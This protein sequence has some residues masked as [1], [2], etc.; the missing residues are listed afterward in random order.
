[1]ALPQR[2]EFIT[3]KFNSI[4]AYDKYGAD[5]FTNFQMLLNILVKISFTFRSMLANLI[6]KKLNN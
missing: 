5:E 4:E 6:L 3:R 2:N 1:M